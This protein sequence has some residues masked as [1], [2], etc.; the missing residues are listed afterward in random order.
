MT[1]TS[2]NFFHFEAFDVEKIS[3]SRW[4]KRFKTA[5]NLYDCKEEKRQAL[6]LHFIGTGAYNILC[7]RL[8]PSQ[9]ED[10]TF[11]EI[12]S[13]LEEYFEPKPSE[14]VEC[15]RFNMRKQK[16]GESACEFVVALRKLAVGC[17]FGAYGDTAIRNQFVFGLV[18]KKL[19]SRLLEKKKLSLDDAISIVTASE[20]AE[21]SGQELQNG[22]ET[23]SV[24]KIKKNNEYKKSGKKAMTMD[25]KKCFRCGNTSHLANQCS[26]KN[27]ICHFCQHKGQ[28]I[29]I[30]E[31]DKISGKFIWTLQVKVCQLLIWRMPNFIFRR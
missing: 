26:Y 29:S 12:V 27:V 25:K 19:Q 8:T 23:T 3:W 5:L 15:F 18:D 20:V 24:N 28:L 30:G 14:L 10:K 13:A 31:V 1:D 9:P 7:D 16:E 17:E 11:Q 22:A 21:K 2:V 4:V 6:L